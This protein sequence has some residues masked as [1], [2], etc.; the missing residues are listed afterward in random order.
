MNNWYIKKGFTQSILDIPVKEET[1]RELE[2]L[3]KEAENQ[4]LSYQR[5]FISADSFDTIT[6]GK[7]EDTENLK[8]TVLMTASTNDVDRDSEIVLPNGIDRKMFRKNPV[9]LFGHDSSRPP[10]GYSLWEKVEGNLLKSF[11]KIA[12]RPADYP[13]IEWFPE[14]IFHLIE[15]KV[16]RGI[17]IG[18]LPL[19]ARP[20]LEKEIVNNP[21]WAAA[22][23]IITKSML[24]EISVVPIGCNQNALVEAVSKGLIDPA[25]VKQYGIDYPEAEE[26]DWIWET[27]DVVI[28]EPKKIIVDPKTEMLKALLKRK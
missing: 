28:P 2:T 15:Q 8:Q 3:V 23:R 22:K 5:R 13:P 10:I 17:S 20:P 16:L 19:E 26:Q 12:D 6:K 24:L 1:A 7:S 21:S 4:G 18:F 14:T 11:V 9:I 25:L 27:E